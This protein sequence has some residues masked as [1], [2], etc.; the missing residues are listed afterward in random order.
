MPA[1]CLDISKLFRRDVFLKE[2]GD[3]SMEVGAEG[4]ERGG[5]AVGRR[6]RLLFLLLDWAMVEIR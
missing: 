5:V 4:A 1:L 2:R 3:A 6:R